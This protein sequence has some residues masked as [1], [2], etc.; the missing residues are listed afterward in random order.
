MN[1]PFFNPFT[2]PFQPTS[3]A[4]SW[5]TGTGAHS[6]QPLAPWLMPTTNPQELE[7]RIAEL[8]TVQ[9]WL[10]QNTR[11]LAATVQ[12]LEV[13]KLTL[14]TLHGMGANMGE[15]MRSGWAAASHTQQP[16]PQ[17]PSSASA[18]ASNTTASS[19]CAAAETTTTANSTHAPSAALEQAT[20][21][22]A[23]QW[24]DAVNQQFQHLASTMQP[25]AAP[26]PESNDK[27]DAKT[28][29]ASTTTS[30]ATPTAATN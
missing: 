15:L 22:M 12:M 10:E 6:P 17:Q 2:A 3:F 11:A 21:H 16:S 9:F 25:V 1:T 27:Q 20:Q 18:T 30:A 8:K 28:Q 24:F 14:A 19:P 7:R 4:N 5:G 23:R 13:Q 26:Q 29:D